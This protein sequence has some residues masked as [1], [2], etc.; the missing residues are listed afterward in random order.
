VCTSPELT[1]HPIGEIVPPIDELPSWTVVVDVGDAA[2]TAIVA[3]VTVEVG[4]TTVDQDQE[5]T[6]LGND[7]Q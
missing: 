6:L 7:Q 5:P 4:G 3:T 2:A 1:I